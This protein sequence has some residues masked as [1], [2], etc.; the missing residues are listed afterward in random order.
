MYLTFNK[1][2]TPPSILQFKTT[3]IS[4]IS[5]LSIL[6]KHTAKQLQ[7]QA[8]YPLKRSQFQVHFYSN[9]HVKHSHS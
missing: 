3:A 4:S 2:I 5:L 6:Q 9:V 1:T 7:C 8:S